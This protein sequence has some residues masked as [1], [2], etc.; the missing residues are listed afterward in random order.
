MRMS[1]LEFE[2]AQPPVDSYG[3]GGFRVGGVFRPGSMIVGPGGLSGWSVADFADLDESAAPDLSGMAGVVDVL[4]VGTGDELRPLP[5]P[6]RRTLE[7]AGL[8]VEVMS[9]ASACRTYNVLLSE[10]RRVAAALIA[11]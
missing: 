4:L 9:T 2:G 3:A 8:G 5:A 10:G 1:E 11:V 7:S 6:L